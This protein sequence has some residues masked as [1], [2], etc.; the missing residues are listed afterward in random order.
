MSDIPTAVSQLT[1]DAGYI[2]DSGVSAELQQSGEYLN[3]TVDAS[4]YTLATDAAMQAAYTQVTGMLAT[5]ADKTVATTTA[6]GL[7][8]ATDKATLDAV[9]ADY[10]AALAAL[11]VS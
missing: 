1:N 2:T 7:M 3:L 10:S 8:S 6:N 9:A 5:K 11:G 4:T